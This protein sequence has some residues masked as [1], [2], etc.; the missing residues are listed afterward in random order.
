VPV[1]QPD[2]NFNWAQVEPISS[3]LAFEHTN[4]LPYS[5]HYELSIE[6]QFGS[7]TVVSVSYVGNQAHRLLTSIE[8]NPGNQQLCLQL[9]DAPFNPNPEIQ[10]CGPFG[11]SNQYTLPPGV[12]YPSAAT[13]AVQL[14]PA[15]TCGTHGPAQ[16]VVNGTYTVLGPQNN[17]Q[18]FGN[19]PSKRRSR[20]RLTTP[21]RP[22]SATPEAIPRSCSAIRTAN[23]STTHRNSSKESTRLIRS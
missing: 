10:N 1:K 14:V 20:S 4:K 7:N 11:E 5:E 8:A 9:N 18:V 12:D 22:V 13:A 23:A 2:P 6:R 16:C 17:V 19:I 15:S 21:Y 3:S